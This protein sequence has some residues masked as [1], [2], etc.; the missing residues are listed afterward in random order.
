[1]K[2][3]IKAELIEKAA[4]LGTEAFH[5]GKGM[6]PALSAE[7]N[8]MMS[9]FLKGTFQNPDRKGYLMSMAM[10][11]AYSRAWMAANLAQPVYLNGECVNPWV[12][13]Q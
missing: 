10:M 7:L 2:N 6:A 3:K 8:A 4:A 12:L 1:M 11:R 13:K 9:P 5:A